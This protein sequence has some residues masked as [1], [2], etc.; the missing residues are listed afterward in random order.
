[1]FAR[2][3]ELFFMPKTLKKVGAAYCFWS[4]RPCVRPFM[5]SSYEKKNRSVFFYS[6]LSPI[7]ELWPF[8][9]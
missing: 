2:V 6:E 4:V 7:V 1:M 3:V 9:F 8:D 5:D